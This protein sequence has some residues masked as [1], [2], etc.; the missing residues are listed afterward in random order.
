MLHTLAL[1]NINYS[2][3][4]DIESPQYGEEDEGD[5]AG[6]DAGDDEGD[7]EGDNDSPLILDDRTA[8]K[9]GSIKKSEQ[10]GYTKFRTP[11]MRKTNSQLTV[12]AE[13]EKWTSSMYGH[14]T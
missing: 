8:D 11:R 14:T 6:D 3:A 7:G 9:R 10:T 2:D 4:D 12:D 5:V 13:E 1:T